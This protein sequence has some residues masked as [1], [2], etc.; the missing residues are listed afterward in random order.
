MAAQ[1]QIEVSKAMQAHAA[2]ENAVKAQQEGAELTEE[3]TA[4]LTVWNERLKEAKPDQKTL[5]KEIDARHGSYFRS[6]SASTS[7]GRDRQ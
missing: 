1:N 6:G 3:Q 5:Q 2:W 4:A 7:A